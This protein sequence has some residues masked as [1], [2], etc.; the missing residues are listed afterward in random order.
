MEVG[1]NYIADKIT[2]SVKLKNG[3]TEEVSWYQFK[4]PIS[5]YD[6]RI[7]SI[8]NFKSIRFIRMFLTGFEQETHLRL[9]TLDLVRGE[10]RNYTKNNLYDLNKPPKTLGKL[11]IQAVNI[12]EN[13][14]KTPVNYVLPPGVTRQTDPGQS[15]MLRQNE[16]AMVMRVKDLS[17]GDARAVYKKTNYDMRNYKRLQMFVHAE[18]M[19][20]DMDGLKDYDLSCFV[21]IGSDMVNNYYEYEIPLR[22][23]PEGSYSDN[24]GGRE[25]VWPEENMFNFSFDKLT[26]TNLKR[27]QAMRNGTTGVSNIIPY[28]LADD[29]KPM[30][31]ITVMGNPSI[32]EV[33]NIMIGIRNNSSESKDGEIW[34][35]ELRMSEFDE[36]GGWAAMANMALA[37]SDIAQVNVAG[38]VETAG[39][40][41]IESNVL[42]RRMDDLYQVNLSTAFEVGRLFPEKAKMQIPLYFSYTNET[43]T[44]QYNPLD[45]DVELKEALDIETTKVARD[46]IRSMTNSTVT[47][48]SVNISN[49]K[50]NIKSKKKPMFYDPANISVSYAMTEQEERN[51]EIEQNITTTHSGSVDYNYSFNPKP[52][53]PFK[54]NSKLNKPAYKLIKEFNIYYLPQSFSASTDMHRTFSQLKLRNYSSSGSINDPMDLTFSQ[55]FVWNR[56]FDAK[57]DLTRN[58]KFSLQTAMNANIDE[59]YYTPELDMG[60][61]V[62]EAWRDTVMHSLGT[63]GSPQ[64]YQQVFTASWNIPLNKIPALDWLTANASY[65]SNYNWNRTA[66]MQGNIDFGNIISSMGAWQADGQVNFEKLYNKSG[67]LKGVN[68]RYSTRGGTRTPFRS[69]K[70]SKMVSTNEDTN[71]NHRLGSTKIRVTATNKQGKTIPVNYKVVNSSSIA[72]SSIRNTD[73]IL[74]NIETLDPNAR[75]PIQKVGDVSSRF[76]MLI[77]RVSVTYRNTNSMVAPGFYPK[78]SFMGQNYAASTYAPGFDFAFGFIPDN[79]LDRAISNEWLVMNDSVISP[80]TGAST[81]D[82]DIK[83][84]LEPIAGLKIDLNGKRYIANSNSIQYMYDGMPSTFTGSFNITQIAI[85]TAFRKIGSAANNYT[86]ET[87]DAFIENRD[88]MTTRLQNEY[89]K[90]HYPSTGFMENHASS[91]AAYNSKLG[92]VNKNSGDVLIPAFL[93]AYTGRDITKISASPFLSILNILPNW[94]VSYDG[95]SRIPWVKDNFKSV[96][97]THA[98]NCRYNIGSYTSYSTWVGNDSNLPTVGFVRDV[99]TNNPIPSSAYDIS[100]VTLTEQFSPLIGV[101]VAMKNSL[102]AK[103]EYRKQRNLALNVSSVQMVEGN[104]DEFV[105]GLAYTLKD[106]D[107]ILKLKE[108]RQKKVSNDLKLSADISYRNVNSLL[109]KIEENITQASSGNKVFG[110]KVMADYTFSSKLNFQ[111]FYDQQSTTPL[112]SSSYPISTSHFGLSIKFMLTR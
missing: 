105:I 70:F 36:E 37:L 27:N 48:T 60:K 1:K 47:S 45:T 55:D 13:S 6:D 90:L 104:N 82:F 28:T 74:L 88:K 94:R 62:Y 57:W 5:E 26:D 71:I 9:A 100:S 54:K 67:Y 8:R 97:L 31:N 95:L 30:N 49:A 63:F 108:D 76:L 14:N 93:A 69:R 79:F 59:G 81:E 58:L 15:Q 99:Q 20:D 73:S 46:S 91:G 21:R 29:E 64:Q 68:Q 11:D 51:A 96:T 106:F 98:Y 18:Q 87:F 19:L 16:Q 43:V 39:F 50:V 3:N 23:T 52:W 92:T 32:G 42:E 86:S 56:Q 85:G 33:E 38:R 103:V 25:A 101:N 83:V 41:G 10:W 34:V 107:V 53:E 7:G 66:N 65:N 89:D 22:L 80:A 84:N 102:T 17:P 110:L 4:I 75:T 2:S 44:P 72:L 24:N 111:L 61:D 12:E 77:R 78:A 109:R 112:I 35:N 40:G